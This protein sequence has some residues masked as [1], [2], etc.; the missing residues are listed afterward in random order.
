[1]SNYKEK[2][3]TVIYFCMAGLFIVIVVGQVMIRM[4]WI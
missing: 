3:P 2:D 1:M 4:G